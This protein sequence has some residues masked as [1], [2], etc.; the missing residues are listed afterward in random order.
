MK[1]IWFVLLFLI[2]C[3][4]ATDNVP[5]TTPDETQKITA[6][7]ITATTNSNCTAIQPFYWEIGDQSSVIV[8]GSTGDGSV[9]GT[10]TYPVASATKWMFGAY[11]VQALNGLIDSTTQ[12]YL[13]MLSGYTNFGN[14]SCGP[15]VLTVDACYNANSNST[16]TPSN[17][18]KFYYN[19]G[20]FQKWA[21]DHGMGSLTKAQLAAEF[22]SK[23]GADISLIFTSPQLAGG[24][25]TDAANYALFLRKILAGQLLMKDHL[26]AHSEC[27]LP[28]TCS[29]AVSSPIPEQ[30][31]Y[32]YGHWVE[33]DPSTGDGAFSSA[34]LFGFYPWIDSSKTYYGIISRYEIPTGGNDI[35]S[36][37]ASMLCGRLIRKAYL[38]GT[39]Q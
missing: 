2:S 16:Y 27:T 33:D 3:K 14:F 37:Y 15:L 19:G 26:G 18:G 30:F 31:H 24:I 22:Q 34:G 10:T 11:V 8:S 38:T 4:N 36:G 7:Q 28:G 17:D 13:K 29:T 39:A 6:A 21:V 9:L 25:S 32:S 20:H 12:K 35:G 23:L 5:R 1:K